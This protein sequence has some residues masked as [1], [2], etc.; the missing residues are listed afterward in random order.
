MAKQIKIE[1]VGAPKATARTAPKWVEVFERMK[2]GDSFH[3]EGV[4][5]QTVVT[6]YAYFCIRGRYAIRRDGDGYRFYL[7]K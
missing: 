6:S 2:P 5:P 3:F 1:N 7:T 4:K